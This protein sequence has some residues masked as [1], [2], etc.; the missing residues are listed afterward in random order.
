[1]CIFFDGF[2][3][4]GT[5]LVRLLQ[6]GLIQPHDLARKYANELHANEILLLAY[7]IAA[8]NIETIYADQV[9]AAD[10]GQGPAPFPGLVLTDTFQSYE[11]GDRQDLDI[12]PENNDR[13][14]RQANLP[15]TVIVGNPPY[16]IGQESQDDDAANED[17]PTLDAAIESTYAAKSSSG[18]KKALYDSYVRAIKWATLRLE[19][20]AGRGVVAYV[21]N[22]GWLDSNT[23]DGMRKSL[24]EEF[25]SIYV[26]NLRGNQRTAG[27]TSRKE[28]GK[29]FG[30]GSRATVA[31][32]VLVKNPAKSGPATIHYTDIGDYLS[33]EEKLAKIADAKSVLDLPSTAIAPN[34]H[35]DWLSQRAE[36]FA[37]F[38]PVAV[39][40]GIDE[41][42]V[43]NVMSLGMVTNRDA[44]VINSGTTMLAGNVQTLVDE[45]ERQRLLDLGEPERHP[46]RIKWTH[47]LT[48][49]L[50]RS[51][52]LARDVNRIADTMYR[53]FV[54]QR[55]YFDRRLIE[56]V[57]QLPKLFPPA[58]TPNIV[59]LCTGVGT[60]APFS[61]LATTA[62]PNLDVLEKNQSFARW[63]YE[64]VD[65]SGTLDLGEEEEIIDG[66][67]RIDN[68]TDQA[69]TLFQS[70]YRDE[71]VTKD[72]IFHYIYGLLHSSAYRDRY[73]ADLKR[74]LPRIPFVRNFSEYVDAG[75]RLANLHVGY[76]SAE[77]YPL[78]G[79]S[80]EPIGDP[81]EFFAVGNKKM[82]FGGAGR[83]KDR[84]VIRYNDRITLSRI[85]LEAYRY[86]LG[87]RSAIE[88]IIDRYYVKTDSTSG[89]VNDPND[90]AREVGDP[91]YILDLLA[92][93]VTVSIETMRIVDELPPLD[94]GTL[95]ADPSPH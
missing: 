17:Y 76:E 13:I 67:R 44:W 66:Y 31:I 5:F 21:T 95:G 90:W 85:P 94:V 86:Q 10:N 8:V 4:T 1:M 20:G 9:A 42:P 92:R 6:S 39:K 56:R 62:M 72:D 87:N 30:G 12:F 81:Y 50:R 63:R 52:P 61:T 55:V 70:E 46:G 16:S 65:E 75:R 40:R 93:I 37:G 34:E 53:P 88:W 18:L 89:I 78:D 3:G 27:E 33:R 73:A 51:K 60:A 26:Y 7:Y 47:N 58:A 11:N 19:Q 23:A 68:I 15:I 83:E 91:R 64:E 36:D 57:Y 28:G 22:G 2:T 54:K 24:A 41:V 43:F 71:T 32:T 80:V 48:E 79:L 38:L 14:A 45:Y 77:T 82:R 74:S 59:V 35:G 25:S 69:L 84:S 29:I 49:D